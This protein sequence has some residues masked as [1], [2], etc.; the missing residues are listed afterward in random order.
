MYFVETEME[1]GNMKKHTWMFSYFSYIMVQHLFQSL[2]RNLNGSW[3][4]DTAILKDTDERINQVISWN[5]WAESVYFSL[6]KNSE[7]K[8][9]LDHPWGLYYT[10]PPPTCNS[11]YLEEKI[12]FRCLPLLDSPISLFFLK[13]SIFCKFRGAQT[14]NHKIKSHMLP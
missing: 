7:W 4:L 14:N 5:S 8:S 1:T 2:N 13:G 3:V 11:L 12:Q 10:L 6:R 9:W